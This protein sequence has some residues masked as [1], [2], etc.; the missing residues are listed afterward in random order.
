MTIA[1]CDVAE[2]EQLAALIDSIEAEH[3]LVA[4]VHTAAQLDDALLVSQTPERLDRALAAKADAAWHLHELTAEKDLAAFVLFSSIAG[5]LGSPGQA[6]YAAANAFLDGLAA[7]RRA[8]GLVGTSISWGMWERTRRRAEELLRERDVTRLT[9][10]GFAA[11]GDELGMQLLDAAVE[12]P[13]PA[14][15]AAP[16]NAVAWRARA[17]LEGLPPVMSELVRGSADRG[18]TEPVESFSRRLATVAAGERG[19]AALAFVCEQI[20]DVLGLDSAAAVEVDR[21]LLELGFDSLT[22]LQLRNRLNAATGLDLSPSVA[23]DHPTPEALAAYLLSRV[24]VDAPAVSGDGEMLTTLMRGAH[25]RGQTAEFVGLLHAMSSFRPAFES[26]EE[27]GLEPYALRLSEGT[28]GVPLVCVPSAAPI[29]GPHEYARLARSFRGWRDVWA[30]RWP[31][32]AAM[33]VVPASLEVAVELQIV[34]LEEAVGEGPLVLVGHSTGGAFAYAMARRLEQLGRPPAAVVLIDTYGPDQIGSRATRPDAGSVG[35]GVLTDMLDA[36]ASSVTVGDVRLTAMT[37]YLRLVAELEDGGDRVARAVGAGHGS[38]RRGSGRRRLAPVLGGGRGCRRLPGGPP[39][40]DGRPRR[41]DRRGGLRLARKEA[42]RAVANASKRGRGRYMNTLDTTIGD[43]AVEQILAAGIPTTYKAAYVEKDDAARLWDQPDK[44]VR[45]TLKIGE[46]PTPELA[47][48]ECL[49]AVMASAMNYNTVWSAR[50]EPI[51]SFVFLNHLAKSGGWNERHDRDYHVLG[52]DA[53]GIVVGVGESVTDWSVGDSAVVWPG[54]GNAERAVAHH[55]V[56]LGDQNL[57]WG[58][59][60]NFGGLAHYA[61]VRTTQLMPKPKHLTW[62]EAAS[63][64]LCAMT[65]YRMLVSPNGAPFKQGDIVFV[66]GAAG[67]LGSY[68]LQLI[69][70]GGGISV[71]V[72]NSEAKARLVEELGCDLVIR[73]DQMDLE[74]L[75]PRKWAKKFREAV[76]AEFGEDPHV[77]FEH[78]GAKTFWASVYMTRPGGSV[79]TC[80]SSTGYEHTFDNRYLWMK[81]KSIVGSHGSTLQEAL[82]CNRLV[83]LGMLQ[84][85][86]SKVVSLDDVP[87]VAYELEA[88]RHVGKV[89][90]L[91]MAPEEGLG[92]EDPERRAEIGESKIEMFRKFG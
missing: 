20:A 36:S 63:N 18:G 80:G 74:G 53:A 83:H 79:V 5:T 10:S 85:A 25:G 17:R 87:T 76:R 51:P 48:D 38:A 81:A 89:G 22:A 28:A 9:R 23:F 77:V 69:R 32:F 27:S 75:E 44:D 73:R 57:A 29:S 84:P 43:T 68:A 4:V 30:L 82:E 54:W 49:V 47:P 15:A 50:F 8:R 45:E 13:R 3:P 65:A 55:D 11:I 21:P 2:R 91:C 92:I 26:V 60:T 33:E 34:A 14:L 6:N 39:F 61:V 35:L 24:E 70:N 40:D 41:G 31:G 46:V 90:V 37:S 16:L 62:E 59:E 72:V 67:G 64:T 66:W 1:S 56:V 42:R 86:L 12:L 71:G 78:V 52:S 58:F 7:E 88:N 19:A